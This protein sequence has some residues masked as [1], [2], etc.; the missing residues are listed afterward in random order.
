MTGWATSPLFS[1]ADR[2]CLGFTEQFVIDVAGVTDALRADVAEQLGPGSLLDFVVALFALDYGR[3]VRTTLDRLFPGWPDR[4]GGLAEPSVGAEDEGGPATGRTETDSEELLDQL[5]GLSRSVARLD[6]LDAITTELVRLRGARQHNCRLCQST[7]S[8]PA[9]EAGAD[10][11]LFDTTERYEE[12]S[13]TEFHK[14]ALRL[15]DAVITLPGAIDRSL[16]AQVHHCFTA[17]Q[18]VELVM[19][20]MRNSAQKIAVSLAA[21]DPH[22][23][24]GFELYQLTE[25]GEVE[26]LA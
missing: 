9:L 14:V 17:P 21:D 24:N 23:T 26:Y 6:G 1:A 25:D 10:E 2:A 20:V 8:L 11:E 3:R 4:P 19:D 22:V 7:R 15:T 18:V 13:L 16:V 12:S 5:D